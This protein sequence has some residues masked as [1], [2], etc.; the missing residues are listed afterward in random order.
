MTVDPG[1]LAPA[2][3]VSDV[4]KAFGHNEVLRGISLTV[5]RGEV[6][7]V[8]GRSG[9]GK[10]TLLR[11]INHLVP[12]DRGQIRIDGK[13]FGS[14]VDQR[15]RRTQQPGAQLRRVRATMPMVFQR[16]NLFQHKTAL[17]NVMEAQLAVL[18]RGRA[19][20]EARARGALNR[21]G[22]GH[23]LDS[24]PM[25]LSGGEQQRVGIARA[26][27]MDPQIILFD[28]PTS[29]LD[30]ELVGEVLA[31]ISEL[32]AEGMT[33]IVVTHAM[34]FAQRTAN[35]IYYIDEGQVAEEGTPSEIFGSPQ[36]ARTRSF[37]EALEG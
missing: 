10:S 7:V 12:P 25:H 1:A 14:Y 30:P 23:K 19:E 13:P 8:I 11:C 37:L 36:N 16:F 15:G 20:A 9:S 5:G 27:A 6:A 35:R 18:R 24:Y 29:S 3:E 22:L 32:A 17:G 21:V 31:I 4:W 28:E 2:I 33:M 26:L 34:R